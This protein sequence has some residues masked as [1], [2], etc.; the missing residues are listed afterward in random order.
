M[1]LFCNLLLGLFTYVSV[2]GRYTWKKLTQN[3]WFVLHIGHLPQFWAKCS[4]FALY[5]PKHSQQTLSW[6]VLYNK[7]VP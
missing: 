3:S 6:T 2:P 5:D 4:R 1:Y 7:T